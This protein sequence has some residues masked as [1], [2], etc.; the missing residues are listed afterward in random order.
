MVTLED[1]TRRRQAEEELRNIGGRLINAQEEERT[2][3][4]RELHDDLS[5]RDWHCCRWKSSRCDHTFNQ[6]SMA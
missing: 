5:Q 3:L 4:A 2:R 6:L 1:V